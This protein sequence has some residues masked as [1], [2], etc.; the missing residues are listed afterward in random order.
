MSVTIHDLQPKEIWKYFSQLNAI[1]RASKKEERV[2]EFMKNFGR[3]LGLETKVDSIGNVLIK[4]PGTKDKEANATIIMQGHLDMV[5]QKNTDTIFDFETQGIN[6][7]VDGDWLKA[8]GTTLGAD[9]GIGVAA[10]MA[11]LAS[12]DMT[13]PPLEAIFTIDE[14]I[15]MTGAMG[16]SK[17][18]LSG[19]ILLNLDSEEDNALTVG[20]AGGVDVIINGNYKM[21][22]SPSCAFFNIS[23]EGLSGGHSGVEIHKGL[24]NAIKLLNRVLFEISKNLSLYISSMSGGNLTNAIPRECQA[25][26]AID[27]SQFGILKLEIDR[28]QKLLK[29]EHRYSDPNLSI[30]IDKLSTKHSILSSAFQNQLLASIYTCP[31]GI[32][33]MTPS[34]DNLVQSS[35]N[36]AK[37]RLVD[38]DYNISCHT[39]SFIETERDDLVNSIRNSFMNV[40]ADVKEVGPYP[41]WNPNTNTNTINTLKKVYEAINGKPPEIFAI[42]AGLEC[43]ILAETYPHLEIVSFGPNIRGAHSPDEALQISSTQRFWKFLTEVLKQL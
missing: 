16:L 25:T 29:E 3:N 5:H 13:H 28:W 31:N 37:I 7:Y 4:K 43:G 15:G 21:E 23:L 32:Y 26:I 22:E 11:V 1:P 41:G 12:K 30:T 39:R 35:N 8:K 34:L 20:S 2:I 38:G 40:G 18:F 19:N 9:N 10:I 27:N 36:I 24:G 6:M 42:H 17:D 33:R 14:E